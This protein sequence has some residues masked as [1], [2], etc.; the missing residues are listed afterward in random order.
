MPLRALRGVLPRPELDRL[1]RSAPDPERARAVLTQVCPGRVLTAP[2]DILTYSYDA[3]GERFW[4]D[5][6]VF[7]ETADEVAAVVRAAAQLDLPVIARGAGTNLSGGTLPVTG[8]IVVC[9]VRMA[10]AA[11]VDPVHHQ[12]EVEPGATNL[13]LE[14]LLA[15]GHFYPPDPASQRVSTIGGNIAENAGGPHAVKYG[16]TGHWV[17]DLDLVDA[18]GRL[19]PISRAGFTQSRYD[20]VALVTG[21]EGTVGIVTRATLRYAPRPQATLTLLASFAQLEAAIATA[22]QLVARNLEPSTLELMDRET[23]RAVEAFVQAGYPLQAEAILLVELDGPPAVVERRLARARELLVHGG[24]IEVREARAAAERDALWR[25]R[26]AAYGAVARLSARIWT[27]DVTVPRPKLP[28]MI[29]AVVAIARRYGLKIATVAHAGDGNLHPDFA[30][31]PADAD[32]VARLREADQEILAACVRLGGSITG[33]HGVGIDKRQGLSLMFRPEELALMQA[34]RCAFDPDGRLNPHKAT[35][36]PAAAAAPPIAAPAGPPGAPVRTEDAVIAAIMAAL[37]GGS[38]VRV[39]RR[40]GS[41]LTLSP[42]GG[43]FDFDPGN[44]TVTAWAGWRLGELEERIA[45]SGLEFPFCQ[46]HP[47]RSLGGL[48]GRNLPAFGSRRAGALRQ[49][50]L[51][52]RWVGG[53]GVGVRFGRPTMKNVAGYNLAALM[54]GALGTLGVVTEV[55]FRLRPRPPVQRWFWGRP[56]IELLGAIMELDPAGMHLTSAGG[57]TAL[58]VLL[59]GEPEEVDPRARQLEHMKG[60]DPQVMAAPVALR[61]AVCAAMAGPRRLRLAV[62]ATDLE[63]LVD[64]ARESGPAWVD[65]GAGIGHFGLDD[66]PRPAL[67]RAMAR[68]REAARAGRG[69]LLLEDPSGSTTERG[70]DDELMERVRGVFDPRDVLDQGPWGA[71]R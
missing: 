19:W 55:T 18:R 69:A 15:P 28:A 24:A 52:A 48:V 32:E 51:A 49:W 68:A 39:G 60:F 59:E 65:L 3:T 56:A 38:R 16:V 47:E 37:A 31:D 40:P 25:G 26:R 4:P 71:R 8:G 64:A 63:L 21:S 45:G 12:L 2:G 29:E 54:V 9:L 27:Q 62:A 44:L 30:F 35:L 46:A 66:A 34:V 67:E 41:T 17:L 43:P 23:L 36:A 22:T 53:D 50:L 42:D 33:E 11:I 70:P 14:A 10:R 13:S 6:V 58:W 57:E 61:A 20:L 1:E 7:P 5:A